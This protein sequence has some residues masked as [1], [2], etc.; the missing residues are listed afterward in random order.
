MI[1]LG[2]V[3]S[4]LYKVVADSENFVL[5]FFRKHIFYLNI[6]IKQTLSNARKLCAYIHFGICVWVSILTK[7]KHNHLFIYILVYNRQR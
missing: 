3:L 4:E 6:P 2:F 1:N 7:L 5:L